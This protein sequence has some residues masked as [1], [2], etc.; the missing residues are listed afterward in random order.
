MWLNVSRKDKNDENSTIVC[1]Q[2]LE[3]HMH[4]SDLFVVVSS[5]CD[6]TSIDSN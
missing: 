3:N 5:G 2:T 1:G 4:Q 6:S